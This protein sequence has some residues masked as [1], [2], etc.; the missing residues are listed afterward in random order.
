MISAWPM[1]TMVIS[2]LLMGTMVISDL[3]MGKM[4]GDWLLETLALSLNL[5]S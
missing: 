5:V 3:L 4:M 2:D 1:G